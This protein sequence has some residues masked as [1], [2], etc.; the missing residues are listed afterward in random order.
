MAAAQIEMKNCSSKT[1]VTGQ[2]SN[3]SNVWISVFS[4]RTNG[5]KIVSCSALLHRDSAG[6]GT[7]AKQKSCQSCYWE[8][9]PGLDSALVYIF[10]S[11]IFIT[12]LRV[13]PT[14]AFKHCTSNIF[15]TLL[16]VIPTMAFKHCAWTVSWCCFVMTRD[17]IWQLRATSTQCA[18]WSVNELLVKPLRPSFATHV[19]T[20]HVLW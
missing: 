13:I 20:W 10:S 15:I 4:F 5:L 8:L 17:S 16:G 7:L 14:M 12:L 6:I 1:T 3:R 9:I 2:R 19:L 18:F 11:N